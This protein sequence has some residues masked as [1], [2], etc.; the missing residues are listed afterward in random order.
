M[1]N[2]TERL[3]NEK[4]SKSYE[5]RHPD[6]STPNTTD[7][8]RL[9]EWVSSTC[10]NPTGVI[11]SEKEKIRRMNE[12]KNYKQDYFDLPKLAAYYIYLMRFGAVDQT[13]KNAMLTTDDG[14]HWYYINYDNDTILGVRNDGR[15][16]FDYT[17]DR[18]SMDPT[19]P[20]SP[21]YAGRN[22]TLWNN[23]EADNE[24]VYN[25]DTLVY[26]SFMSLVARI[27]R[28][29]ASTYLTYDK[30]IKVFDE[31]QSNKWC[32]K[33][34]NLSQRYKYIDRKQYLLNV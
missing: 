28:A 27:D 26:E 21:V 10:Q 16:V 17:I 19:S 9:V 31:E 25:G 15:L 24:D 5:S 13:V 14:Q 34:Y 23:L 12:F 8:K 7:L 20:D 33:L 2:Y 32:E 3:W 4:W 6:T 18:Q 29:I 11:L 1:R 22:S 30:I